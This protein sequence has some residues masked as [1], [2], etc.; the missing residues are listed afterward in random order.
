MRELPEAFR[1]VVVLREI[2]GFAYEEIAEI[3]QLQFGNG[4]V[5]PNARAFCAS[6]TPDCGRLSAIR[7]HREVADEP[8]CT[9][10][11]SPA[12]AVRELLFG[13]S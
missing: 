8:L 10:V 1:T 6:P 3:S 5:P 2:E 12:A 9:S 4:E 11:R 13:L 7:R